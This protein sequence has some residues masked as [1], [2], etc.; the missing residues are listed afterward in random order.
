[1][2]SP[3]QTGSRQFRVH[4]SMWQYSFWSRVIHIS[5]IGPQDAPLFFAHAHE[6][7]HGRRA[8]FSG[9]RGKLPSL[10]RSDFEACLEKCLPQGAVGRL[11]KS[12]C[13]VIFVRDPCFP[14][15]CRYLLLPVG[16]YGYLWVSMGTCGYLCI[17]GL[18]G[19][20]LRR[21]A[22]CLV[23][24]VR[25]GQVARHEDGTLIG[26]IC[27]GLACASMGAGLRATRMW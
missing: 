25:G 9:E 5:L 23:S 15:T 8:R 26:K 19:I 11:L 24:T 20:L 2:T 3:Y 4:C 1:M 16:I 12:P 17:S 6:P 14:R 18:K 21:S 13:S 7:V 22:A 10:F 27:H